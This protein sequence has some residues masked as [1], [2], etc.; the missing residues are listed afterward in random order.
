MTATNA[1][2]NQSDMKNK[3]T[4]IRVKSIDFLNYSAATAIYFNDM[5]HHVDVLQLESEVLE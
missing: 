4:Q 2:A 3:Y 5:T 1:A